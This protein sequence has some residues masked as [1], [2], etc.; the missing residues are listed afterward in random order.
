FPGK[1]VLIGEVGWPS[2]GRMREGAL[3]SPSN[4]ARVIQDTLAVASRENFH[5]NVIEAFD[6]PWKETLEGAVGGHWGLLDGNN[7]ALKFAWGAA[8]STHPYWRWQA[9]AG[10]LLALLVFVAAAISSSDKPASRRGPAD[11]FAV[12]V[13]ALAS[14]ALAGLV[15]ENVPLESLGL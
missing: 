1:E 14:G 10:V 2:A 13:V 6:Q 3:P 5:V 12:A 9:A 15:V 4:Q 8:V 11:W 7:G